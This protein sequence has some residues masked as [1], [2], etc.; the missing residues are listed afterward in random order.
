MLK[1]QICVTRPQ[2]VNLVKFLSEYKFP[3]T[4]SDTQIGY[5]MFCQESKFKCETWETVGLYP[6]QNDV[7]DAT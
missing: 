1:T 7:A 2:C 6:I 4:I 3:V 5:K